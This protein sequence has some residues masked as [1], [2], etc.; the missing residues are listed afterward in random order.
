MT[1]AG[2]IVEDIGSSHAVLGLPRCRRMP[3]S[4]TL[5]PKGNVAVRPRHG[6]DAVGETVLL[7]N[8]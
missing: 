5:I 1:F 4:T 8:R 3:F 2:C 7:M 6:D